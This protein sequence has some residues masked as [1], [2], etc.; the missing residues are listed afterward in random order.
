MIAQPKNRFLDFFSR[1]GANNPT[2]VLR[3][4]IGN[5]YYIPVDYDLLVYFVSTSNRD[6]QISPQGKIKIRVVWNYDW[7]LPPLSSTFI[8][9]NGVK[10][11]ELAKTAPV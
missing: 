1:N 6:G 5:T 4:Y 10:M 2:I 9:L 7:P 3:V 8:S 11:R